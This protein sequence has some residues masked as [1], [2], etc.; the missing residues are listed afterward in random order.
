MKKFIL[1]FMTLATLVFSQT[2]QLEEVKDENGKGTGKM[3][4]VALIATKLEVYDKDLDVFQHIQAYQRIE[5]AKKEI[6]I[7]IYLPADKDTINILDKIFKNNNYNSQLLWENEDKKDNVAIVDNKDSIKTL[8]S[9]FRVDSSLE[10]IKK[11]HNLSFVGS[12]GVN[13]NID[14]LMK[15][16][17]DGFEYISNKINTEY[18]DKK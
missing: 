9:K 12:A 1:V 15:S 2:F 18:I 10:L 8:N 13:N 11:Y 14:F 6:G 5:V 17:M 7:N 4:G 3:M 16:R